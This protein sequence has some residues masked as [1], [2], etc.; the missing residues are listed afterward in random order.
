[1]KGVVIVIV[2]TFR[3]SL[4]LTH[5]I[6]LHSLFLDDVCTISSYDFYY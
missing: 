1:M 2:K 3:I 6:P 4:L 5:Y